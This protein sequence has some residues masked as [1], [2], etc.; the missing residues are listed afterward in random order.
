MRSGSAQ[1]LT[2]WAAKKMRMLGL[3]VRVCCRP[4]ARRRRS[5]ALHM[6]ECSSALAAADALEVEDVVDEADEAV[7]VADGDLE[8]L[9]RLLGAG[10]ECAAGEQAERSAERGERRAELVGDGGDEL[11]LHAVEGAALGGV[12]E[13]DDDAD[14]LPAC[15]ARSDWSSIWGRA[16]Y[17]TGKLVPSL[18][19]KTSLETRT[20]SRWV[21]LLRMGESLGGDRGCRRRGC[22]G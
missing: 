5:S 22:G 1:T 16:T 11:V 12:G 15:R 2:P 20:V 21:R 17:S 9:L 7:G 4:A 18:R 6:V 10:G 19:Q 3:G 14:G 8:H 13:G